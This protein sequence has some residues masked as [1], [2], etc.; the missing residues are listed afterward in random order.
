MSAGNFSQIA[1]VYDHFNDLEI[2]ERWLDFTLTSRDQAPVKV[3][4]A[5][6]G[7]GW[8]TQ[9][10]APFCGQI[11]G[12]DYDPAMIK[13]AQEEPGN[14]E[15]SDY[16]VADLL[17]LS[18]L[19]QDYDLITCYVDSLCFLEGPDQVARALKELYERLAPGGQLLFDVWT[20]QQIEYFDG[21]S[22]FD[23]DDRYALLW[24]SESDLDQ[25]SVQHYL[26]VFEQVGN[27]YQRTDV[28][29]EE[30]TYPLAWYQSAL[31]EAGFS[32]VE[33]LVD[34]G[35]S[36]YQEGQTADRWFFRASK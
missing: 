24:D 16:L 4:D 5:A 19:D 8:F 2:Y 12:F 15:N 14:S 33:V 6:C 36:Y 18:A 26:T 30:R 27:H 17:D 7:T 10:L 3:L 23:S 1:H 28:N 22:Y 25:L 9:L 11:L 31:K 21:F 35:Q 13:V 20:P 29:L 32:Q 34:F